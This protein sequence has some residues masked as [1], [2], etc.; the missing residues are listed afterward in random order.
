[1]APNNCVLGSLLSAFRKFSFSLLWSYYSFLATMGPP[2]L[3]LLSSHLLYLICCK[4]QNQSLQ[5]L[6]S[7]VED[8]QV[9]SHEQQ[10]AQESEDWAGVAVAGAKCK[11]PGCRF[12]GS[13]W[14]VQRPFL[15]KSLTAQ[16][17]L[18]SI[19]SQERRLLNNWASGDDMFL[20][21]ASHCSIY[22][23]YF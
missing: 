2:F 1:M 22:L 6:K 15:Q 11:F 13:V 17:W 7:C 16:S 8:K 23:R 21:L 10:A 3:V 12:W 5:L 4:L 20:W 14:A 18:T 9:G 19:P